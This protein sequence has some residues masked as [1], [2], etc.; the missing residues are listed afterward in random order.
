MSFLRLF[1]V[2]VALVATGT[3]GVP[4]GAADSQDATIAKRRSCGTIESTS[5]YMRARVVA[6]RGV[7]CR[8][9]RRV[10]KR[11]DSRGRQSPHWRCG[12]AHDDGA[13]LFSCGAGRR[14]R[15]GLQTKSRALEAV[16]I[17]RRSVNAA[18]RV[19]RCRVPS[20]FS[21]NFFRLRVRNTSCREG[22]RVLV[23]RRGKAGRY[24]CTNRPNNME[25]ADFLCIGP[26]N[27]RVRFS[28]GS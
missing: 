15:G 26:R 16:G 1:V 22:R 24:R 4:A 13:R 8:T 9:A 10:A 11:Y 14:G 28:S 23:R 25:G 19:K 17:G 20:S 2:A 12:L 5:I 7:T 18:G 21:D 27:R 3:A 6:I